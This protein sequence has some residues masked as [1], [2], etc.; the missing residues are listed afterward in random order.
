MNYDQNKIEPSFSF[1]EGSGIGWMAN[2]LDDPD[3]PVLALRLAAAFTQ[4]RRAWAAS[5]PA[6]RKDFWDWLNQDA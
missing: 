3:G 6:E 1:S 2:C 4:V 5:T